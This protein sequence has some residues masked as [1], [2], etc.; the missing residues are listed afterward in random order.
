MSANSCSSHPR[1][2]IFHEL[3]SGF[4]ASSAPP[5]SVALQ[6][7]QH[8]AISGV[9]GCGKTSLLQVIAGLKAPKS[10]EVLYNDL[11]IG[12]SALHFWRQQICYFPQQAVMGMGG[13]CVRDVLHLPWRLKAITQFPL[14][15]EQACLSALR[16]A[17]IDVLLEKT[18][19][20]LSG[21]EKQRVAVARGL[22]M[23]REIWLMDEPT[24]ALD[25]VGRD[26]IIQLIEDSSLICISV[27]HD[28]VWLTNATHVHTMSLSK[29]ECN[30]SINQ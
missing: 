8:L 19:A 3:R 28:P 20:S 25:P 9:S 26:H 21:G 4:E 15:D 18:I 23:Q 6:V 2:L 30:V 17:G 24:S 7:G 1:Q 14:P 13:E 22:L 29:D 5:L 27:S 12:E 10:G 16:K 11:T